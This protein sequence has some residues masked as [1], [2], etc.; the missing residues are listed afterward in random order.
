MAIS[1]RSLAGILP[2]LGLLPI[3]A[4]RAQP[5][6]PTRPVRVVNPYTPGGTTEV[7]V[8]L[9]AERFER[10]TGQPMVVEHRPGAGGSVGAAYVA[11]QPADGYTILITNTGP[12]A[13]A[14]ALFPNRG[15]D[16]ID[17]FSYISMWGGAPIVL[18]VKGDGPIRSVADYIAAAKARP[19][20][21]SFGSS[22]PG[23]V[24][25]LTGVLFGQAAGV[26]LRH[27]PYRGAPEAQAGV[28]SGEIVS[29]FDTIGA[30]AAQ[31]RAGGLRALAFS[32]DQRLSLFPE[33]PTM[34]E[35]GLAAVATN[36]FV[37]AGPRGLDPAIIERINGVVREVKADAAA[38]ER[39][40]PLGL[41]SLGEPSQAEFQA[42]IRAEVA[43]WTPVVEASGARGS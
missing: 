4:L 35:S 41:Q 1:R 10:A 30:H 29:I 38:Q 27:V 18:A 11:Q 5:A 28:I 39:M 33:V 7:L 34:R 17:S 42:F 37:M 9:L 24:G 8:R 23:S 6:W 32:G 16:V 26:Q 40:A 3:P 43:K 20:A 19:N 13:V 36:W 25:H 21:V 31:V 2:A 15:Y 14:Q 22:G 12:Q